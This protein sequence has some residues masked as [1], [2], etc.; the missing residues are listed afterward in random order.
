[1]LFRSLAK[2]Y[3]FKSSVDQKRVASMYH[4]SFCSISVSH[5]N[6]I[7][8]YFSDR[9][10]MCLAS[11]RPVISL[12]F[13]GWKSYFTD[14]CDLVIADSVEQIPQKVEMLKANPELAEF[15]GR[16]GAAK[17]FAEHTYY[18]RVVELLEMT[19]LKNE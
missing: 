11:G 6:D 13:P 1:M 18:S 17:V 4:K 5:F 8:H 9:L 3:A 19:G 12:R 16:S 10:L 2:R 15:I 7:N 14:M